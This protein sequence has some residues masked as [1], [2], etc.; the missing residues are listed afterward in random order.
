[1][2]KHIWCV[3]TTVMNTAFHIG[4]WFVRKSSYSLQ[5]TTDSK[6]SYW[7]IHHWSK[8]DTK[9]DA[10][11]R[12][13]YTERLRDFLWFL[14]EPDIGHAGCIPYAQHALLVEL[15]ANQWSGGRNSAVVALIDEVMAAEDLV[16]F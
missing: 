13:R 5:R 8:Y 10:D 1:M 4:M 2:D 12:A 9:L 7:N 6:G 3:W 14:A 16:F 15:V 11:S